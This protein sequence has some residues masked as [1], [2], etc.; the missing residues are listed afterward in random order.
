MNLFGPPLGYRVSSQD[1]LR[2][3]MAQTFSLSTG[4][5]YPFASGIGPGSKCYED[6]VGLTLHPVHGSR[7]EQLVR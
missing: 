6:W 3:R 2:Q 5:P 4:F 7:Y 1:S